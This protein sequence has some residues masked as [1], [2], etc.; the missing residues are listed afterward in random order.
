MALAES[1][2]LALLLV[3]CQSGQL[4]CMTDNDLTENPTNMVR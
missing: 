1:V 3:T 2:I 4:N